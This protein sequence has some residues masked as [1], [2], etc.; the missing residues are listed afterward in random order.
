[1]FVA[2]SDVIVRIQIGGESGQTEGRE[3]R[4]LDRAEQRAGGFR[5][6]GENHLYSHAGTLNESTLYCKVT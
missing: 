4:V 2:D 1:M 5:Q 6:R 3:Q